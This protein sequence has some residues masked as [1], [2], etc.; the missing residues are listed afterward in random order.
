M[1][2]LAL[3]TSGLAG[4][5]A[6]AEDEDVVAQKTFPPPRRHTQLL[7]PTI[8]HLLASLNWKPADLQLITVSTGPGSYTGLRVGVTCAKILAYATGAQVVGVNTLEVIAENCPSTARRI[9]VIS[10]AQRREVYTADLMRDE[11]TG[12][13][14]VTQST[15]I[16]A[17]ERWAASL[18]PATVV[19]GPGLR[20]YCAWVPPSCTVLDEQAWDPRA[21]TVARRGWRA[22]QS[23]YRENLL[24]LQPLYLRRSAAEEKWDAQ[25]QR[26]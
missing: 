25:P 4:D 11:Q 22:Y 5:V 14:H 17:V 24:A 20:K 6:L 15:T 3:E 26:D 16:T 7:I 10:D 18:I 12:I 9:S 2:I 8:A 13:L 23:G 19:L 1:R 21:A